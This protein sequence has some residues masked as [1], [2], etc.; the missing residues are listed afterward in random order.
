[1]PEHWLAAWRKN[2]QH[3]PNLVIQYQV[4]GTRSNPVVGPRVGLTTLDLVFPYNRHAICF[5]PS[6]IIRPRQLFFQGGKRN[7][8]F[9]MWKKCGLWCDCTSLLVPGNTVPK[10]LGPTKLLQV[11]VSASSRPNCLRV[12]YERY[13]ELEIVLI[14]FVFE[15]ESLCS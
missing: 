3:L 8:L 7:F 9:Y 6:L 2:N 10:Y 14:I 13:V 15:L 11:W 12:S 5:C 4:P 1:M